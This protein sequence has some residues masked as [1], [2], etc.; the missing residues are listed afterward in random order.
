M[1]AVYPL[2]RGSLRWPAPATAQSGSLASQIRKLV[3][4]YACAL[5]IA[6]LLPSTKFGRPLWHLTHRETISSLTLLGAFL[7]SAVVPG[8]AWLRGAALS[9]VTITITTLAVFGM[10]FC[11]LLLTDAAESKTV[12]LGYFALALVLPPVSFGPEGLDPRAVHLSAGLI[13]VMLVAS[14]YMA[15]Q[16]RPQPRATR[17]ESVFHTAFYNLRLTS[18]AGQIPMPEVRGGGITSLGNEFL[19]GTGDGHLYVFT[20]AKDSS[21]LSIRPLSYRVPLNGEEFAA[22]VDRPYGQPLGSFAESTEG[23]EIQAWRFRVGDVLAREHGDHVELFASHHYWKS[24]ERC[25]VMRVSML[26]GTRAQLLRGTQLSWRTI[27]ETHPCVPIEGKDRKRGGNPFVGMEMGGRLAFVDE[28]HLLLT[29]GDHGFAGIDTHQIFAQDPNVSYGKTQIIPLDGSPAH[30]FTI[31]HRNPQ[32]LFIDP[33]GTMWETEHGP[34][35]G[36]ELNRLVANANYGWPLVTYGTNIGSLIWPSSRSQGDHAG[37]ETPVYA[38]LP[39]IGVSNLIGIE[40][41]L[42]PVWHGDLLVS[43]L[44]AHSLWRLRLHDGHVVFTER[45][46]TP[47]RIRDVLEAPDGRILLWTD[48]ATLDV[49]EPAIDTGRELAFATLCSGCHKTENSSTHGLGPNL[50][51]VVDRRIATASGYEEYSA[52]LRRHSGRWTEAELDQFLTAPQAYSPG[53]TMGFAG[54]SDAETRAAVISHLKSLH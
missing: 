9:R 21:G 30:A 26:R 51:G 20:L 53:T 25:F 12:L 10:V 32:G 49:L 18:Y 50:W 35:G 27:Y 54:I 19:L 39:S 15:H 42:F 17:Q 2:K 47:R 6:V 31:G 13:I 8:I 36:D 43:S 33:N 28:Q 29:V 11:G 24:A 37:Y 45:I 4:W 34:Q 3:P 14:Y 22:D 52:A 7:T 23:E 44:A 46:E 41:N 1:A 48:D 40:R 16:P 5:A 38:W